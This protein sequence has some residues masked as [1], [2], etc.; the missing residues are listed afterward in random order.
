VVRHADAGYADAIDTARRASID[1]P[2]FGTHTTP[3]AKGAN[4]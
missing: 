1:M 2:M 3:S 4:R